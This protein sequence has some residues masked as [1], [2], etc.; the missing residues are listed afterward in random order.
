MSGNTYVREMAE[1]TK[2]AWPGKKIIKGDMIDL[3]LSVGRTVA[4]LNLCLP[5]ESYPLLFH[6]PF[7]FIK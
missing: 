4:F 1:G 2:E 6:F 7:M 3:S 5:L